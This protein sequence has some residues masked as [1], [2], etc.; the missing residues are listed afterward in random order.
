MRWRALRLKVLVALATSLFAPGAMA[1]DIT[2]LPPPQ[3]LGPGLTTGIEQARPYWKGSGP[4]RVFLASQ[5]ELGP[6]YFRPTLQAGWGK[7][8]FRW[9]G[10][11]TASSLTINGT[12]YYAGLRGVLPNVGL[13][14]GLRYEAPFQLH[15]LRRKHA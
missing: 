9:V 3:G 8:H 11:E 13:R 4:Q 14:V 2:D 15:Y 6:L 12:R 10:A 5:M 1:Q 7:P